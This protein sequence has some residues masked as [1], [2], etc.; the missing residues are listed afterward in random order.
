MK[1]GISIRH[2][3]NLEQEQF[4]DF[5]DIAI[6]FRWLI[7]KQIDINLY[8]GFYY[9]QEKQPKRTD[10]MTKITYNPIPDSYFLSLTRQ[11]KWLIF[12]KKINK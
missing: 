7:H 2:P 11:T 8:Q 6:F 10:L 12:F 9:N 1:Y 5:S 3:A 4:L